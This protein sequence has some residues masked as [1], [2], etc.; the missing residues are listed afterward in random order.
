[1]LSSDLRRAQENASQSVF[2]MICVHSDEQPS[3]RL[4]LLLALQ[5]ACEEIQYALR[6]FTGTFFLFLYYECLLHSL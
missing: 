6:C 3:K 1:M 5:S 2:D 4:D